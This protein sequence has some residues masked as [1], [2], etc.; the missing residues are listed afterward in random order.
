MTSMRKRIVAVV[1]A[2]GIV[3][4][5]AACSGSSPTSPLLTPEERPASPTAPTDTAGMIP[6]DRS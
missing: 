6:A 4:G 5:A 1:G 3:A 2:W